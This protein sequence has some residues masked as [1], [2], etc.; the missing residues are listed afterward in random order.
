MLTEKTPYFSATSFSSFLNNILSITQSSNLQGCLFSLYW[1]DIKDIP[2]DPTTGDRQLAGIF[3]PVKDEKGIYILFKK[4]T[5]QVLYVGSAGTGASR[6]SVF[7]TTVANGTGGSGRIEHLLKQNPSNN[8]GIVDYFNKNI[9]NTG[10]SWDDFMN[11][12][13]LLLICIK[14]DDNSD[15]DNKILTGLT[16]SLRTILNPSAN[17]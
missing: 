6:A 1:L 12:Y 10:K 17:S 4:S 2:I 3:A 16:R 11:E 9:A 15:I 5:L 13:S 14:S 8:T 7:Y